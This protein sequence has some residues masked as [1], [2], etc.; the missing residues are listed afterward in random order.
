MIYIEKT[1]SNILVKCKLSTIFQKAKIS[2]LLLNQLFLINKSKVNIV[3][4][5]SFISVP[6]V[7]V[8]VAQQVNY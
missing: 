4:C 5:I 2:V 7:Y 6:I 8:Q 1:C 3:Q